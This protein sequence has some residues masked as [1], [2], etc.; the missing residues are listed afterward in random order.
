[1][2]PDDVPAQTLDARGGGA[3]GTASASWLDRWI[4]IVQ[5]VPRAQTERQS[6]PAMTLPVLAAELRIRRH[7]A[8][9]RRPG[10]F[11]VLADI[12]DDRNSLRSDEQ[13]K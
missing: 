3:G 1:M 7:A 11:R 6:E 4:D 2:L 13:Q 9:C 5:V 8:R 12:R 10:V